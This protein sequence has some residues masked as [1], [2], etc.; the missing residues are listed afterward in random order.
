[1]VG[2]DLRHL[3]AK[4]L[5]NTR[6]GPLAAIRRASL[7]AASD[8]MPELSHLSS[9][10][11]DVEIYLRDEN[12]VEHAVSAND[13]GDFLRRVQRAVAR[14]AKARRSRLA[15]VVRLSAEDFQL[16]RFNVTSASFGSL[17]VKLAPDLP[18]VEEG[19]VRLTGP[20]WAE[21]GMVEL[22][23]ALPESAVDDASIDSL[24]G[25]SPVVRRA[26]SDLVDGMN[27]QVTMQLALKR[28]SG[29]TLRS[30][31]SPN[32]TREIR[33]R[34]DVAREER[35]V[36]RVRG[37]L[38]GLRT[39]RQIFYFETKAGVEIHGYVDDSLIEAVKQNLDREVDVALE[40]TIQRSHSGKTS[41]KHYRL[42]S[43]AG[44]QS[45]IPD[46]LLT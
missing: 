25:A 35:Q 19:E 30:Q 29:E 2:R 33:R 9:H 26:V 22:I 15:D 28:Q 6:G 36:A 44:H 40:I 16:A 42:L 20:G 39:R 37:R 24:L 46:S 3:H 45:D 13:A 21:I 31:L 1:M 23:R 34:L 41:Q 43:V 14:L 11:S 17:S 18:A 32:Q 38:D 8:S 4:A 5:E 12:S 7:M 10:S 27:A